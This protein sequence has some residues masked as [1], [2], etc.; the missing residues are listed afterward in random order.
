M[1]STGKDIAGLHRELLELLSRIDPSIASW[2]RAR[3]AVPA[4][5]G[6]RPF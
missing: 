4:L 1:A 5:L 6:S 2:V 3:S